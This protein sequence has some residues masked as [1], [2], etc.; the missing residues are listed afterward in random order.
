VLI[1]RNDSRSA[2]KLLSQGDQFWIALSIG[3]AATAFLAF[4]KLASD[5][6]HH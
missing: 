1:L 3:L 5:P 4:G 6:H 2:A